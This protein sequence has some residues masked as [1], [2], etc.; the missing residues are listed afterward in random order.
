MQFALSSICRTLSLSMTKKATFTIHRQHDKADAPQGSS[1]RR[2]VKSVGSTA[3]HRAVRIIAIH[4]PNMSSCGH[5][6]N[7]WGSN[8]FR[9]VAISAKTATGR[10]WLFEQNGYNHHSVLVSVAIVVVTWI[11]TGALQ[12]GKN[13]QKNDL[14]NDQKNDLKNDQKNDLKNDQKITPKMTK[15]K[16]LRHLQSQPVIVG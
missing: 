16:S 7:I 5:A 6:R 9:L 14:K 13:D 10:E 8:D 3:K 4:S 15:N 11:T 12:G 2:P 1:R